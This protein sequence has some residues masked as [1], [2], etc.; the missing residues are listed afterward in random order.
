MNS[1]RK[2]L[3][4]LYDS[5]N[6]TSKIYE[7]WSRKHGLTYVEMQLF[8][9]LLEDDEKITQKDLCDYLEAPKTTINS[10]VKKYLNQQ[11]IQLEV[12]PV[13]KKEKFISLTQEGKQYASFI[14][15]LFEIE[16]NLM[17][18]ISDDELNQVEHILSFYADELEKELKE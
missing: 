1:Q 13:N 16:E 3:Y 14:L 12:N 4:R 11:Y 18:K 2:R 7:A 6:R 17:K 10:I 9:S 8:Y 5:I 15:P